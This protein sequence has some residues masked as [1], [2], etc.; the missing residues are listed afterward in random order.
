MTAILRTAL[1]A[2]LPLLLLSCDRQTEDLA[3]DPASGY[4][5]L[6][7]GKFLTYRLDSTVFTNFG[8][9]T[10]IH[11][12]Q[13]KQVVDARISDALGRPSW[14][15]F[16]YLRDTAGLNPWVPA[17]SYLIT[18]SENEVE[19]IEDNLRVI[20]LTGPV[21]LDAVWKGNRHLPDQPYGEEYNFSNDDNMEDWEYSYPAKGQ[22]LTLNGRTYSEVLTLKGIDEAIN[23]PLTDA[24][25]YAAI[26]F[27]E[28]RYARG[29]GL[30]LQEFIMWEYQPNPN[31]PG[32]G[33]KTG[34]GVRRS[35]ID[36]N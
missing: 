35:L 28:E 17:G 14:R 26:N 5:P 2:L 10:E 30:I 25:A 22:T 20:K 9:R 21:T 12:Y 13:E 24:R 4:M 31:S 8:R 33:F 11:S 6:S 29:L 23:V 32:D 27:A 18:A 1:A 36:H 16:R 15:V 3:V 7:A 19:V 34:F